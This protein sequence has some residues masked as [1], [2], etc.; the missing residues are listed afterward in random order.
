MELRGQILYGAAEG[1]DSWEQT[2]LSG[3]LILN[4]MLITS[5][6]WSARFWL[7]AVPLG[8]YYYKLFY[9][10]DWNFFFCSK[11]LLFLQKGNIHW[12]TV[13]G[14][15]FILPFF[16]L[17]FFCLLRYLM[18]SRL[19]WC[20]LLSL[21]GHNVSSLFL[22]KAKIK[23]WPT[24]TDAGYGEIISNLMKK[25]QITWNILYAGKTNST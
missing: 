22:A 1:R 12:V 21:Y 6:F 9:Y 15:N 5:V 20:Q 23:K 10:V 17:P 25:L 8:L 19:L 16:S 3:I 14:K 2:G 18:A 4:V 11:L 13:T 7:F 24:R